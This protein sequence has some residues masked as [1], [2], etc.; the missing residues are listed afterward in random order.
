MRGNFQIPKKVYEKKYHVDLSEKEREQLETIVKKRVSISEAVK[1]SPILLA[2]DRLGTKQ[3]SDARISAEYK[4]SIR[5][6]ERLRE[7][8]VEENLEIALKGKPRPNTDKIQF[9]G[10]V[11]AHWIAL[12][13]GNPPEGQSRWTLKLLADRFVP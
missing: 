8:F 9:D 11:E 2:A 10:K 3:W 4:G 6:V 13:C 1:R 12:R 7:R 5:T